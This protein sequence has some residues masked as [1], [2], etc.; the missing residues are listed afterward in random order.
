VGELTSKPLRDVRW[1]LTEVSPPSVHDLWPVV[2]CRREYGFFGLCT[3][4]R[5]NG[6]T[7]TTERRKRAKRTK[8][9]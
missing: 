8:E 6:R 7:H 2:D 3:S 9:S 5:T 4:A 1:L